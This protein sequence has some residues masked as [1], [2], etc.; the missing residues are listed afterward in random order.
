RERYAAEPLVLDKW[1][2]LQAMIPEE[3]T[4]ARVQRLMQD[5]A[6][7]MAN[8]NRVRSLVGAFALNNPTQFHRGDG[9][10]YGFLADIVLQLDGANPQVAARLLTAFGTWKTMEAGRRA[11][12]EE[13][14][15]RIADSGP[16]SPDVG[17]I[18]QRSLA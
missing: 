15:R 18:V 13:A 16:L 3:S 8:P 12:A 9:L 4:L 11:Q 10:G 7:S 1:F 17:D 5:P 2:S 6:F 14:L